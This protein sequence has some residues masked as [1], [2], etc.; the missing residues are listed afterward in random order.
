MIGEIIKNFLTFFISNNSSDK[1][2]S[3]EQDN[4]KSTSFLDLP[5]DSE[6]LDEI[7]KE[8]M[9]IGFIEDDV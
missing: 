9:D 6:N 3:Q 2:N 1:K 4:S 5:E 8:V 7:D